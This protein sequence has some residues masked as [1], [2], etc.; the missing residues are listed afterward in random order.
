MNVST[1]HSPTDKMCFPSLFVNGQLSYV[2]SHL[3]N[4]SRVER[5]VIRY[6]QFAV[7]VEA[8]DPR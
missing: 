6:W 3:L 4:H 2:F 1:F 7:C 8:A 5:L